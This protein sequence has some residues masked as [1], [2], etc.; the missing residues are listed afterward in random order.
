ML[1][2]FSYWYFCS[3]QHFHFLW[4]FN[5]FQ[6][7]HFDWHLRLILTDNLPTLKA[8]LH[9]LSVLLFQLDFHIRWHCKYFHCLHL[10]CQVNFF[11]CLHFK[12]HLVLQFTLTN[13][14]APFIALFFLPSTNNLTLFRA[15]TLTLQ[16]RYVLGF[17]SDSLPTFNLLLSFSASVWTGLSLQVTP[18]LL[19]LLTL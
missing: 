19:S 8:S 18:Q 17:L 6:C 15:F 3:F 4:L 16:V 12:W 2:L 10:N 11:Q 13:T 5:S 9:F 7:F 1:Q 14:S